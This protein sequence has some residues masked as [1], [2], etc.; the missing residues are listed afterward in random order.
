MIAQGTDGLFR[1]DLLEGVMKGKDFLS[2][3]PHHPSALDRSPE[4][5]GWLKEMYPHSTLETL[6]PED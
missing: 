3:V 6:T 2:F 4:L 5:V 1:R